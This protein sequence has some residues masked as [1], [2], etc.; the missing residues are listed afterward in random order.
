MQGL[1]LRFVVGLIM[2]H[3]ATFI[4]GLLTA[5]AV[6]AVLGAHALDGSEAQTIGGAIIAILGVAW[7]AYNKTPARIE[8]AAARVQETQ[9]PYGPAPP[10]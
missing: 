5:P 3:G 8:H 4:G 2:R 6:A 9:G 10:I 7:S 1:I